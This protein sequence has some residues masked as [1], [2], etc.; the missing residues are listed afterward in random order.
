MLLHKL[1]KELQSKDP[2]VRQ[3]ALSWV[4]MLLEK[5]EGQVLGMLAD[6]WRVLMN[7]LCDE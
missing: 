6:F 5:N 4:A 3:Q 2:I 1:R 7:L